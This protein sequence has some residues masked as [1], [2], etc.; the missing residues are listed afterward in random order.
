VQTKQRGV[1]LTE[2]EARGAPAGEGAQEAP[3][4][5]P[6]KL[7]E[8]ETAGHPFTGGRTLL[9]FALGVLALVIGFCA[10]RFGVRRET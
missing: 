5:R 2:Q 7:S 8:E 9:L 10:R 4:G 3:E 6:V 1:V